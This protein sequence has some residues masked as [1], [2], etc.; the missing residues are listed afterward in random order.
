MI[1]GVKQ[2]Y[3]L[4]ARSLVKKTSR[5]GTIGNRLVLSTIPRKVVPS[6][7]VIININIV[8]TVSCLKDFE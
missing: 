3:I 6:T 2:R 5:S 7:A 4:T 8:V 1:G